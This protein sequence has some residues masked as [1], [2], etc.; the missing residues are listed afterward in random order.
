[1]LSKLKTVL[2][3]TVTHITDRLKEPGSIRSL[4]VI[5]FAAKGLLPATWGNALISP[6]QTQDLLTG[7]VALLGG[8]SFLTPELTTTML[9]AL[10]TVVPAKAS[11]VLVETTPVIT[12]LETLA[13]VGPAVSPAPVVP[14]APVAPPVPVVPAVSLVAP[15]IQAATQVIAPAV[16]PIVADA[17]Q[18]AQVIQSGEELAAALATSVPPTPPKVS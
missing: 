8:V 10:E 18:V 7:A 5:L 14:V 1:M 11:A 13:A 16:A 17:V 3:S 4:A 6:D 2:L 15:V 12:T 9:K